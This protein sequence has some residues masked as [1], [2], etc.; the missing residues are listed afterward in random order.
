MPIFQ[1]KG[2]NEACLLNNDTLSNPVLPHIISHSDPETL[3]EREY[4]CLFLWNSEKLGLSGKQGAGRGAG[5][6]ALKGAMS[7]G[8]GR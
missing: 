7:V 6:S 5:A 2:L 8:R 3:P 4:E 1:K